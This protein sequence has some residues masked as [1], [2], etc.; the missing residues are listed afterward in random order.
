[1]KMSLISSYYSNFPFK[2]N[3]GLL[4]FG[5]WFRYIG[6]L[7]FLYKV[8]IIVV[9][10]WICGDNVTFSILHCLI[11]KHLQC[12]DCIYLFN[13]CWILLLCKYVRYDYLN[14]LSNCW[15]IFGKNNLIFWRSK[16]NPTHHFPLW[17]SNFVISSR[18]S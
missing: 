3:L 13:V 10:L 15:T 9:E 18:S 4:S 14:I 6:I 12:L 11:N 7:I 5:F 17:F 16:T 1:M 2:Y 8:Q